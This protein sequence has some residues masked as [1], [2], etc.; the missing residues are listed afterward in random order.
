MHQPVMSSK[1]KPDTRIGSRRSRVISTLPALSRS[2][3]L[4]LKD[5]GYDSDLLDR[6][7]KLNALLDA[8]TQR[9]G[10]VEAPGREW[11][12]MKSMVSEIFDYFGRFP[13]A[14]KLF[15][16]HGPE[17]W[18]RVKRRKKA[19][20]ITGLK[21]R[22]LAREEI[23]FCL[24][25][26][27]T[28]YRRH[29]YKE[30]EKII[31]TCQDVVINYIANEKTFPCHGTLARALYYLGRVYR[32]TNHYQDAEACF[33]ESIKNHRMRVEW[34]LGQAE[35]PET[36][37][38]EAERRFARYKSAVVMALGIGWVRYTTGALKAARSYL[39]PARVL[40][41]STQD[42]INS[43]YVELISGAIDRSLAG[44][45]TK[46]LG[47]ARMLVE[48]AYTTF[49]EFGHEAYRARAAY[50]LSLLHLCT[51]DLQAAE[52]EQEKVKFIAEHAEQRD[53]RWFCNSL[54]VESRIRRE[55]RRYREAGECA[56]GA[57][58]LADEYRQP[59]CR[60]DALIARSEV[61]TLTG[62]FVGARADLGEALSLNRQHDSGRSS[63]PRSAETTNPKIE[64]LCN[65]RLAETYVLERNPRT[66]ERHLQRWQAV[67][68]RVEH[69]TVREL[70]EELEQKVRDLRPSFVIDSDTLDL[71]AKNWH[72]ELDRWLLREAEYRESRRGAQAKMLVMSRE[73]HNKKRRRE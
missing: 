17:V 1:E 20:P 51:G 15:E 43:A 27:Q 5:G 65:L 61:R 35:G 60:I 18:E 55:Q 28:F 70:G 26:A 12:T 34:K 23:R 44:R 32:Q 54:I 59:L 38:L 56:S 8:Q 42:R 58:K 63:T 71:N 25:Y 14:R 64:G 36:R 39:E 69:Q 22:R 68:D 11:L 52:R 53:A 72:R 29:D 73:T 24:E 31:T 41:L 7:R 46:R 30:A 2:I 33:V 21:T 13:E 6:G 10:D 66:A 67:R 16:R 3:E 4:S 9:H 49:K 47:N 62:D 50:E 57:L 19:P 45:D 40:L 48:K 37:E